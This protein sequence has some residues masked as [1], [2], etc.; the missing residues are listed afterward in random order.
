MRVQ[1][2][3]P[4][5]RTACPNLEDGDRSQAEVEV[6]EVLQ[7]QAEQEA[8]D[9]LEDAAVPDD[10]R[11]PAPIGAGIAVA[12]DLVAVQRPRHRAIGHPGKEN[13]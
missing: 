13:R 1:V 5:D 8:C 6:P 9:D 4:H 2:E 7:R 11:P 12:Q 3:G 10:Q